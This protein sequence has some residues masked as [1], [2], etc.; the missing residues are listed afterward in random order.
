LS[1][2]QEKRDKHIKTITEKIHYLNNILNDFLSLEKLELGKED[3]KFS[4]FKISKIVNEVVYNANMLLKE[5][6]QIKYPEHIDDLSL[7][8][9]EKIIELALSNLIHN[10]IKYSPD[11][12]I[13]EL[14]VKQNNTHTT[15]KVIDNGMGIPKS[16]QKNIFN[17]YFRAENALLTHGTGIGLNIVQSHMENLG[18]QVSF[19]SEENNGSTFIITLPNKFKL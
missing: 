7:T 16:D 8:Q 14:E 1:E 11:H 3:Y 19:K 9:D 15:F 18:G 2:Q 10:A 12:S 17:R 4:A 5:G 6:Q 13:I